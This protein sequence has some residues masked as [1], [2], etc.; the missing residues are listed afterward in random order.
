MFLSYDMKD[1]RNRFVDEKFINN[2]RISL[3][4]LLLDAPVDQI[5]SS[6]TGNYK[7]SICDFVFL[8][9]IWK[10]SCTFYKILL[11]QYCYAI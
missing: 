7:N 1:D 10:K 11:P 6:A 3:M 9:T 4:L 5:Q 8:A 2:C